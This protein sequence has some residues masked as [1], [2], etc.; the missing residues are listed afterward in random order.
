VPPTTPTI[1]DVPPPQP[2]AQGAIAAGRLVID[3]VPLLESH[4]GS[5]PDLVLRWNAMG[6]RPDAVDVVVHF[7]GYSRRREAMRIDRDK[8]PI[9]GLDF[10]DPDAP[11]VAGRSTPTLAVLPRGNYRG[12]ATGSAYDF[13]AL[14]APDGVRRL[15]A[16]ALQQFA[17]TV[18]A[19]SVAPRRLLLTAHSGG[20]AALVGA[21]RSNDPDEVHVFDGL[22]GPA[23][24]LV[25]WARAR[26]SGPDQNAAMRVLYRAGS[27]TA[28]QSEAV[29]GAIRP[30]VAA[31]TPGDARAQR[32]RVEATPEEHGR[33][34]RAN[35]WLL[36]K[37]AGTDLPRASS[38]AQPGPAPGPAPAPAPA[39]E[40]A[41]RLVA[42]A[43]DQFDRFHAFVE[44]DPTLTE[45]IRRYWT[46]LG[47]P[48]P[49]VATPWSAVFVSWCVKQA[50][51]T[52]NEFV[53]AAQ[54]S[55]FVFAAIQN[56][57]QGRG[58]FRGFDPR[59]YA[60]KVGDVVQNNRAGNA[61]DYAYAAA[62]R[63]YPSHSAIVVEAG[64]DVQGRYV[65][66]VGG[67]ESNSV[68][69]RTLRL[70]DD[71]RLVDPGGRYICVVQNAT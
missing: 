66:T 8:E 4:R 52:R 46:E 50:G 67:N 43:R 15:V 69:S 1:P 10:G 61:F 13:P 48:S 70:G 56:K 63:A 27:P 37:D 45:Q 22:Y 25:A 62:H 40:R 17:A 12:G 49:G 11:G 21:L 54:H 6:G 71:G 55:E 23:D 35:G 19:P 41:A 33:I 14:L 58:V 38:P 39:G 3:R 9:S 26:L 68:R 51:V 60:P 2:P 20:G 24:P 47:L 31:L 18:G 65:R 32:F 36:L 16:F 28:P 59:E 7:H 53:F 30:L 5:A 42:V 34:P 29:A 64:T 44:T 57:T